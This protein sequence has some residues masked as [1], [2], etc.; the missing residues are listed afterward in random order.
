MKTYV[1][2]AAL[3]RGVLAPTDAIDCGPGRFT[4]GGHVIRDHA[5][6]GWAGPSRVL[7]ESSNIGAAHIGA[8]L[9][10]EGLRQALADF[11][12]GERTDVGLPGE[13]RGTLTAARSEIGLATQ[14]FGQGPITATAL[15]LT[16]AM[17]AIANGGAWVQPHV[18]RRIVDPVTGRVLD[19]AGPG[20]ARQVVSA[21][22]AATL[23]RWLVGVIEDPKGT[24]HRARLDGWSAAG[25]TGTAQKVDRVS[26]GYSADR[27]FSSFVG[28]AP[29]EAPRI[30]VGV[31]I[32]EPRGEIY[33]GEVAAP[34]FREISEYA[35]RMMG[36]PPNR[37]VAGTPAAPEPPVAVAAAGEED[38]AELEPA[39]V[40]DAPREDGRV[41]VPT[42]AGLPARAA[43]RHLEQV[44]LSAEV[45]G[46]GRVVAQTPAPG[47]VVERGTRVRMTL[48]PAG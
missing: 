15:Q 45:R 21:R 12:F 10:R 37:P 34:A 29:A 33:G 24:G 6:V 38:E 4:I 35:L 18:I 13:V 5:A 28:F 26:G 41:A 2:A 46:S 14:S 40:S 47:R 36:V 22:T 3:E 25:K 32:D 7:A 11:G 16:A 39:A 48:S 20:A 9:G 1:L 27:H 42:L 31:F 23:G 8:R 43:I 17:G 30:V 44:E 19:A